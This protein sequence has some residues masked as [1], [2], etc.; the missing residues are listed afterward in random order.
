MQSI[1]SQVEARLYVEQRPQVIVGFVNFYKMGASC[2]DCGLW[3]N[4]RQC[5]RSAL[6]KYGL[7]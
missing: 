2:H 6:H 3:R 1:L 7:V 5:R 4:V